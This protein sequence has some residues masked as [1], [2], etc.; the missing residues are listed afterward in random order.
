MVLL[1]WHVSII[2]I[3]DV[4]EKRHSEK[5]K[6]LGVPHYESKSYSFN[7]II[8]AL[9]REDIMDFVIKVDD[10]EIKI[11]VSS[12]CNS[13]GGK[14]FDKQYYIGE[15]EYVN[16]TEFREALSKVNRNANTIEVI[17]IDDDPK[18]YNI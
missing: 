15:T 17:S 3:C 5:L 13:F 6:N 11:G 1:Q 4:F 7:K 12:D 10:S 14:L 18:W 2:E 9:E 16:I 8:K